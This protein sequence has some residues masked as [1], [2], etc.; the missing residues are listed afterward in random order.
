MQRQEQNSKAKA[1]IVSDGQHPLAEHRPC[2]AD[3]A[4][5]RLDRHTRQHLLTPDRR[6]SQGQSSSIICR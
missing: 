1:M 3:P 6:P 4:L 5:I 2:L